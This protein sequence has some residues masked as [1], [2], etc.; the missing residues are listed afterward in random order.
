[1]IDNQDFGLIYNIGEQ[2]A[3]AIADTAFDL[4]TA[5]SQRE[6][7]RLLYIQGTEEIDTQNKRDRH[8]A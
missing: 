6:I 7:F 2:D 5:A 3:P 4:T 1:M 8:P